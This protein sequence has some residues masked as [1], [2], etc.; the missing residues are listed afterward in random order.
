MKVVILCAGKS[1]RMN[2]VPKALISINGKPL[3][4]HVMEM[5]RCEPK[6]CVFILGHKAGEVMK[7][8]PDGATCAFQDFPHGIADAILQA[9]GLVEGRFVVALGDCIQNIF[10]FLYRNCFVSQHIF[11]DNL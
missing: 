6:D 1:T 11:S 3:I 8:I 5:W 7:A 10:R 9:E 4:H 2:Q